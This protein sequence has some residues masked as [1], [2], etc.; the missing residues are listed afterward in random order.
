MTDEVCWKC[1]EALPSEARFCPA[2]G[3]N[4]RTEVADGQ[5]DGARTP[6]LGVPAHHLRP[7]TILSDI[8]RIEGV[9]GEG[10]MGVVYRATD[11]ALNRPVAIKT[12]H[13]NLLGE[14]RIRKRFVREARIMMRW[15]HPNVVAVYDFVQTPDTLAVVMELVDGPTLHTYLTKWGSETP[16]SE[17]AT[18]FDGILA[19][20]A[21]AHRAGVIHRDLKPENVL[22]A[23]HDDQLVAK[24]VDFGIAKLL[25]GT[26]YTVTGMLLGT[27]MYMSPEQA[28][29]SASLDTR[30]DIYSVG[31]TLYRAVTGVC[32]F[33]SDNHFA[34]M[35]AHATQ[36]PAPPSDRR[37]EIPERLETLILDAL[38][39][40]PAKRPQ[41]CDQFQERLRLAFAAV[42]G[43]AADRPPVIRRPNRTDLVLVPAGDF[44]MGPS[45]R[46]VWLD[47]FYIQRH[48]VT[49]EQYERFVQATGYVPRDTSRYLTHWRGKTCPPKLRDHP[50]TW[51]SWDDA[52]AYA[53]WAGLR[54]PT[55]AEWEKAARGTDARR[56]PWGRDEPTPNHARYGQPRSTP[57][58]VGSMNLGITELGLSDMSGNV[59]QWCE[60]IDDPRFY[61]SGPDRN[62]RL[63]AGDGTRVVRGGSFVWDKRALRTYARRSLDPTFRLADVGFRCARS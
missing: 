40:V 5:P 41:T 36:T 11:T 49:N 32:P 62:P 52:R 46:R 59:Q 30:S 2:C 20:L 50:V 54:L 47:A 26:S 45:K 38:E 22:L 9:L 53:S 23:T 16:L 29:G 14:P 25:E 31:V 7:G 56:Y 57:V 37:P 13:L 24:V 42:R 12:L 43:E 4:Q 1:A 19:G 28:A 33:E 6:S 60:D 21:E 27:F 51:V 63:T 55:E 17:V 3:E 48:P 58:P 15:N 44:Q 8:Y 10:G 18:I 35:T 61:L 34:L 39:K